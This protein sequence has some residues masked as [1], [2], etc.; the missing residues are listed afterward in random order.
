M[1]LALLS[2]CL[3]AAEPNTKVLSEALGHWIGK[4]LHE[5]PL[6]F[7]ALAKG[8][9]DE[10]EGKKSP[11]DEAACLQALS[12]LEEHQRLEQAAELRAQA[13]KFLQENLQ[14][15][16]VHVLAEGQVQYEV[17]KEGTGD[18]VT[19]YNR[20]I[21]RFAGQGE[22]LLSLDSAMV[23]LKMALEGMREGEVRKIFIH[24][25]FGAGDALSTIE[26]ELIQADASGKES[27]LS[28]IA[29]LR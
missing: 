18:P 10:A 8:L 11:I 20:P 21:V 26:I 29:P 6:D 13:E 5:L 19:S 16:T 4:N 23:G 27:P 24:P 1:L 28:E 25:D 2:F 15:P 9:Q 22:E 3:V 7:D 12:E 17:L 14:N